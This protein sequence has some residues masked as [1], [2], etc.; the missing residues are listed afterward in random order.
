MKFNKF[1]SS[2]IAERKGNSVLSFIT[3]V[4]NRCFSI[5]FLKN[6]WIDLLKE[7]KS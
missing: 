3:Y 5:V 6:F 2:F 7:V 4:K 1:D